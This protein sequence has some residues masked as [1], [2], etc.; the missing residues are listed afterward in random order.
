MKELDGGAHA[1]SLSCRLCHYATNLLHDFNN[2]LKPKAY[3]D[4]RGIPQSTELKRPAQ[5]SAAC[6]IRFLTEPPLRVIAAL[7]ARDL[8]EPVGSHVVTVARAKLAVTL[9]TAQRL[10]NL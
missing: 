8:R 9:R 5:I 10:L 2:P 1:S 4:K 6:L 3:I 7:I